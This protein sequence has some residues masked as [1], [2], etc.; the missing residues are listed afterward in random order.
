M[1]PQRQPT[2]TEQVTAVR[3]QLLQAYTR[4]HDLEG[5]LKQTEDQINALR[6]FMSA[7]PVGQK[8]EQ[9]VQAELHLPQVPPTK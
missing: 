1:I 7:I 5:Q 8:L 4:K 3:D 2:A 6:N 9:E